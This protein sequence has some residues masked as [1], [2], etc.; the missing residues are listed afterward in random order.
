V[1]A[2][3]ALALAPPPPG[4]AVAGVPFDPQPVVQLRDGAGG[5]LPVAGVQ[6]TAAV[7]SGSGALM[8]VTSGATDAVGRAT[9]SGLGIAGALGAHTLQFTAPGF[10]PATSGSIEVRAVPTTTRI[11]SDA[12]DPSLAGQPVD[13]RFTVTAAAGTPT[14]SVT[15]TAS[16]GESCT[17]AVAAGGCPIALLQPGSR[18]LTARYPGGGVL[19][20][21]EDT[22]THTVVPPTPAGP[23]ASASSVSVDPVTIPAITGRAAVRVEVRDASNNRL[24]GVVVQVSASGSGNT[25]SPGS[26]TTNGSGMA[27]FEL[28]STIAEAK[29]LTAVA[30]GVTL[31]QRPT[32]IVTH[33]ATET[34]IESDDPDPSPVGAPVAVRFSVRNRD[35]TPTGDVT[36]SGGGGSCTTSVSV[37]GCTLVLTETGDVTLTASYGGDPA[38]AGSEDTEEHEVRA[39]AEQVLRLA[40]D[41]SDRAVSGLAFERQPVVQ[42]ALEGQGDVEEPGVTV[43]ARLASGSGA[44]Q[45]QPTAVTDG[46][47]RAAFTDLSIAGEGAHTLEF[48]AAGYRS[49][50]SG[51]IDVARATTTTV[52]TGDSPDPSAPDDPVTVSFT[53]TSSAGTPS[54]TVT[55][56]ASGGP[57]SCSADVV[58]GSCTITLSGSGD[59]ELTAAYGGSATFEPSSDTE[60]HEVEAPNATPDAADDAYEALED[61]ENPLDISAPG[62]LGNDQDADGD[63]LSAES[64][65]G[66]ANG[67][68]SLDLR[69]GFRY[70]PEPDFFGDDGFTYRAR[71][72]S[73]VSD[74]G[75]VRVVVRP[76]NDTPS[77]TAGPDQSAGAG[78]G[79]RTVDGWATGIAAGPPNEAGQG[80]QF[81]VQVVRGAE[82]FAAGP[83]LASTGALSYTPAAAGAAQV[84]VRLQDDGGTANGG[85]DT[86]PPVTITFS[87]TP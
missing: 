79:P 29:T 56:T 6:V 46:E 17:G 85:S 62:V 9:F 40:T 65:T 24:G 13:V 34:R 58:A 61:D 72:G 14:G 11:D 20:P 52:I 35:G 41:P 30:G 26:A 51:T 10:A 22:E 83:A 25:V 81:L 80:L 54:G 74:P 77:F 64:L 1:P 23:S 66:P 71:D 12:P 84:E 57:E 33:A 3:P 32:I 82:L 86:S 73:S 87:F 47:G 78:E 59:R 36:V 21:S 7:A 55:V 8:G 69:G 48:S 2:V 37:G 43:S 18:T 5:D 67:S 4:S 38:F 44:L 50:G 39:P 53:V 45:G 42:L 19:A 75:T 60:P 31:D 70:D 27:R 16:T 15:V 63:D 68:L 49:V 28:T 76:V